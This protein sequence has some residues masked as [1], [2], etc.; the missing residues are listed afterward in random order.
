MRTLNPDH[1]AFIIPFNLVL[2]SVPSLP[3]RLDSLAFPN[4]ILLECFSFPISA[5]YLVRV[6]ILYF[7]ILMMF[8][9][10]C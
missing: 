2:A 3:N 1:M 8:G 9:E 7:D 10:G 6:S 4:K 5:K